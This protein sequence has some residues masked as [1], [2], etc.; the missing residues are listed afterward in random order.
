MR[1][2]GGAPQESRPRGMR[3]NRIPAKARALSPPR[4][5]LTRF[6]WQV[7]SYPASRRPPAT[8][9]SHATGTRSSIPTRVA[10][11][12]PAD[13]ARRTVRGSVRMIAAASAALTNES[14]RSSH[15]ARVVTGTL[16]CAAMRGDAP[17]CSLTTPTVSRAECKRIHPRGPVECK[18]GRP[19]RPRRL[20]LPAIT[21]LSCD[22]RENRAT[23]KSPH[24][25]DLLPAAGARKVAITTPRRSGASRERA[26]WAR[27]S[28]TAWTAHEARERGEAAE[29]GSGGTT[30]RQA[31]GRHHGDSKQTVESGPVASRASP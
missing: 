19:P 20:I 17:S 16:R 15:S 2:P 13:I 29:I 21:P 22:D 8:S 10:G 11:I 18:H 27:A 23:G 24:A 3:H 5:P 1:S 9:R 30:A 12:S 7:K 14:I 31:G 28:L 25:D 4:A 26:L 6:P